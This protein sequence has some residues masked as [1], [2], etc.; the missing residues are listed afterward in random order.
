MEAVIRAGD[1]LCFASWK[2]LG[3]IE[4][5][6]L[7]PTTSAQDRLW[8]TGQFAL[9]QKIKLICKPHGN[10]VQAGQMCCMRL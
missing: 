7:C 6:L 10:V 5:M 3:V 8:S 1:V 9:H 2:S 4:R